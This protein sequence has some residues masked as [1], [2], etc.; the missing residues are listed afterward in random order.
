MNWPMLQTRHPLNS[1][2]SNLRYYIDR[3]IGSR[4]WSS[5]Q[6]KNWVKFMFTVNQIKQRIPNFLLYEF[7]LIVSSEL[8]SFINMSMSCFHEFPI[9]EFLHE[10][11]I[12][13]KRNRVFLLRSKMLLKLFLLTKKNTLQ[14]LWKKTR[15][16]IRENMSQ[17]SYTYLCILLCVKINTSSI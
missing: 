3:V 1:M 17:A 15:F 16:G 14:L 5:G 9:H 11:F 13:Q 10:F 4:I 8:F 2:L 7:L 6:R 12:V